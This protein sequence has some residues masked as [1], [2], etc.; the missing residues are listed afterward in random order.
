MTQEYQY[1]IPI[2]DEIYIFRWDPSLNSR[3]QTLKTAARWAKDDTLN[4]QWTNAYNIE[5]IVDSTAPKRLS[6]LLRK[7]FKK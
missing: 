3:R 2:E 6:R 1:T 7:L 4:F 5:K